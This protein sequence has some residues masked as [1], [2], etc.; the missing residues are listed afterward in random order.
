M[1]DGAPASNTDRR[2]DAVGLFITTNPAGGC[3]GFV[4]GTCTLIGPATVLFA[5]HSLDVNSTQPIP[6]VAMRPSRVR[7]R[8][9]SNGMSENQL[10][11]N[12]TACHG[13]YQEIDVV[14][15][16]DAP[17]PTS[18]QAL[19]VLAHAPIGIQPL[20][21]ELNAPPVAATGVILAGWGYSGQCFAAGPAWALRTAR[22]TIPAS[23]A[24]S[25]FLTFTPCIVGSTA[26][27][28][29][30]PPGPARVNANLHDSGAPILVEKPSTDATDP[31][32]EL[33]VV[34][35]VSTLSYARRP[36]AWNRAGGVPALTQALPHAHLKK[37]DFDGSGQ[38]TTEDV[39]AYLAAFLGG[40]L[41][42]DFNPDNVLDAQDLFG[43][44]DAWFATR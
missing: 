18:D 38:V 8:R 2:L 31:T 9:A 32:P 22:G 5:R 42:A 24:G 4:S 23:A 34:G 40:R 33:R 14:A 12:G 16:I 44:L 10:N 27:C 3:G 28:L 25:D 26:P 11:V 6:S 39:F 41:D 35:T 7:F 36:S 20:G 21:I 30:C 29:N 19:A 17:N 37:A 13:V 43:Y 1:V 15:F